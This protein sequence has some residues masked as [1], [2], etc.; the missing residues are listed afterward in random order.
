[1]ESGASSSM[2]SIDERTGSRS[3]AGSGASRRGRST[4]AE[5]V[6]HRGDAA[7]AAALRTAV[8]REASNSMIVW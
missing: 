6:L 7:L 2:A 5:P 3:A 4:A 8:A 1:M